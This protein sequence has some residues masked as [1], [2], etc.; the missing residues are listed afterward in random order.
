MKEKKRL[1]QE[2]ASFDLTKGIFY[3]LTNPQGPFCPAVLKGEY[4]VVKE[5]RDLNGKPR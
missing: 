5:H 3:M 4:S 2:N 1:S